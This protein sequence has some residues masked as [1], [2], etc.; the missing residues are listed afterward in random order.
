MQ[1]QL[2]IGS[3]MVRKLVAA[4]LQVAEEDAVSLDVDLFLRVR[5]KKERRGAGLGLGLASTIVRRGAWCVAGNARE[6]ESLHDTNTL[7]P[8]PVTTASSPQHW[9]LGEQI[10]RRK[11]IAADYTTLHLPYRPQSPGC[12]FLQHDPS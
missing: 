12:A 9:G 1:L 7:C 5:E 6:R 4:V 8:P 2:G 10:D 11:E 3:G